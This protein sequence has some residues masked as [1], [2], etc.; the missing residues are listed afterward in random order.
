[1][2]FADGSSSVQYEYDSL[3][4]RIAKVEDGVRTEY[5]IDPLGLTN[6]VAEY[7][8]GGNLIA[9]YVHGGFGLVSRHDAGGAAA[10]YDFDAHR[11]DRGDDG[12]GAASLRTATATCP[13]AKRSSISETIANPFEFVGQFGVQR[14]GN[15][16]D[17]MRVRY[18]SRMI[19]RFIT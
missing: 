14:D 19:G 5:L 3:G 15:G 12:C 4:N 8:N 16:L 1:M 13:S 17:F 6:V 10:F 11:L 9:R 2:G 7:D 18:Y